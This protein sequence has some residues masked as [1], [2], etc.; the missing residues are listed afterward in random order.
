[1]ANPAPSRR[2]RS[3][4]R[5]RAV[6]PVLGRPEGVLGQDGRT[7]RAPRVRFAGGAYPGAA[8][9]HIAYAASAEAV[10]GDEGARARAIDAQALT[11]QMFDAAFG[12]L[13]GKVPTMGGYVQGECAKIAQTVTTIEAELQ[14]GQISQAQAAILL[15]MQKSATRS[16]LLSAEGLGALAVEQAIN[17]ALNV[18]RPIVNAALG[19]ALI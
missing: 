16:V 8:Q 4:S 13:K 1:M 5:R 10:L 17:A 12:V 19:F 14:S 7:G 3:F 6:R 11:K 18:V 9:R 15:D 2:R